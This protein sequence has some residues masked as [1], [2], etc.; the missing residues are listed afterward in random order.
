MTPLD[1]MWLGRALELATRAAPVLVEPNPPVGAV[2]ASGEYLLGEGYHRRFGGPHAEI[3]ALNAVTERN[4][5]SGA[6]LYVTL[7]P[8]CHTG[9]KTPPCVPEILSAGI[10]RVVIGTMDPNPAV[11]GQG[12]QALQA[13]GVEVQL[14]PDARPFRRL[15]RHFRINVLQERPYITLKWAQTAPTSAVPGT[16]GYLGSRSH[17]R[18]AVSGFRGLV[19][20][21]RLRTRHS[22]IAVGYR[23]WQMDRPALTA[24]YFPGESPK[25]LIFYDPERGKPSDAD[26]RCLPLDIPLHDTMR[27]LY[28]EHRVG[29]LL[30]EG[31]EKLLQRFLAAGLYDEVHILMRLN[32]PAPPDPVPAPLPPPLRWRR[33]RLAP[34]EVVW[35]GRQ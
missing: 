17:G 2:I 25:A 18:W 34:D 29:S 4:A 24:R 32:A 13:A 35:I 20:G 11:H 1:E 10:R 9:K 14:A 27:R 23:T 8:C 12:I 16:P 28:S 22:H 5:L 31:G 30:I 6:T 33:I 15:L 3:E 7:E 19:W 21:H 26:E